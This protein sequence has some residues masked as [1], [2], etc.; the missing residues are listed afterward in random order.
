MVRAATFAQG[1]IL[2]VED[3]LGPAGRL[4]R[5]K[6][7]AQ[8]ESF[9]TVLFN[10]LRPVVRTFPDPARGEKSDLHQLVVGTAERVLLQLVIQRTGGNQLKAASLLGVNRNT[11]KRK[12]DEH[13]ISIEEYRKEARRKAGKR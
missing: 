13:R 2:R 11:L 9:E 8:E 6:S 10:R 4:G 12:L 7:G 3:L 5:R 1:P